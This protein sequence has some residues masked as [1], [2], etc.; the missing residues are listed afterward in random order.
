MS[1]VATFPDPASTVDIQTEVSAL[2]ER[3]GLD[4]V[5]LVCARAAVSREADY[6]AVLAYLKGAR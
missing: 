5:L 4:A 2:I 3:Y 6:R 1:Q